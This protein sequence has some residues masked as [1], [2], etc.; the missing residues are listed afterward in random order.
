MKNSKTVLNELYDKISNPLA[1]PETYS[2]GWGFY[3]SEYIR[4]MKREGFR[5]DTAKC[6]AV[7][8]IETWI[9]CGLLIKVKGD[10]PGNIAYWF[11]EVDGRTKSFV[12]SLAHERELNNVYNSIGTYDEKM[13]TGAGA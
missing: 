12:G 1:D 5:T 3:Q 4:W 7:R 13:R 6:S 8:W 11:N 9:D 2:L 10:Q